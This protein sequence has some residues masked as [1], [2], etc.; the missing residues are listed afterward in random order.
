MLREQCT[1]VIINKQSKTVISAVPLD[2][3]A[4]AAEDSVSASARTS[5]TR[6]AVL[7][8][9]ENNPAMRFN[10]FLGPLPPTPPCP[11]P[12][13]NA[14]VPKPSVIGCGPGTIK[15]FSP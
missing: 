10:E 15:P 7:F 13:V 4:V 3:S 2:V 9:F 14:G 8:A 12:P 11:T 6:D 1:T 5:Q